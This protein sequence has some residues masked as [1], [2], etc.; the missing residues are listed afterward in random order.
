MTVDSREH[1]YLESLRARD[2][3]ERQGWLTRVLKA[4]EQWYMRASLNLIGWVLRVTPSNHPLDPS[5]IRSILLIRNDG[6]G[7]MLVSPVIWRTI[8][9]RYPHIKLGIAGSFRNLEIVRCEPAIDVRY[10]LSLLNWLQTVRELRNARREKWDVVMSLVYNKRTRQA[11]LARFAAPHAV[12]TTIAEPRKIA[13]YSRLFDIAIE[14]RGEQDQTHMLEYHREH[15]AGVLGIQATDE[16]LYP[17]ISFDEI[18]A[19]EMVD[20]VAAITHGRKYV[21]INTEASEAFREW[22]IENC[23]ELS[24]ELTARYAD[25]DILWLASPTTANRA[26]GALASNPLSRVHFL[27][28]KS[29]HHLA[30]AIGGASLLVSPDTSTVHFAVVMKVPV[31]GLFAFRNAPFYPYEIPSRV[32]YA[33]DDLPL[34]AVP[35]GDVLSAVIELLPV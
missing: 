28:T 13:R 26:M 24:G 8:R 16:E 21:L 34:S 32:L 19:A 5:K 35:V 31:V 29:L 20:S 30:A 9:S 25:L 15:L 4:F 12:S 18:A 17:A 1:K 10:D 3:G 23:L 11:L 2:K 27:P 7:D 33:P 22:G 14:S 6:I